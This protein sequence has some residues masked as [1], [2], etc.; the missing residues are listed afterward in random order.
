M[1]APGAGPSSEVARLRDTRVVSEFIAARATAIFGDQVVTYF[2]PVAVFSLTRDVTASGLA[3]LVQWLPRILSMPLSGALVDRFSARTQLVVVDM[4]RVALLALAAL[5]GSV[6]VMVLVSGATT[7]LNGHSTIATESILGRHV[8]RDQYPSTQSRFQAAQQLATVAGPALAG[9]LVAAVSVP[10]AL[11]L[12]AALFLASASWTA[13]RFP[14]LAGR[15]VRESAPRLVATMRTGARAVLGDR[16]T[17][18]LVGI[19]VAV[20]LSGSLTL[21]ALPSLVVGV[22]G[23]SEASVGVIAAAATGMSFL[24]AVIAARYTRKRSADTLLPA[25]SV[26]LLAG[27]TGA[28]LAPDPLV[29]G[30]AYGFWSAGVT[31]FSVWMRTWRVRLLPT[32]Q[33][34][35]GLGVFSSLI[36]VTAPIAGAVLATAGGRWEVQTVLA[37]IGA[38]SLLGT[39]VGYRRFHSRTATVAS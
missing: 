36:L 14:G 18:S 26:L 9:V 10:L 19:T 30:V 6:T 37:C 27:I 11:A 22:M 17:R 12:I 31:L 28:V 33:L 2:I 8:P 5:T 1:T 38:I 39:V 35:A 3:F 29:L 13:L 24:A 34:G 20:N 21:A 4:L 25:T 16:P 23:A 7:L 32:E 15:Q